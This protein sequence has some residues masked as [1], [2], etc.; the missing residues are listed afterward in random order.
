[1]WTTTNH[2]FKLLELKFVDICHGDL[3]SHSHSEG[4][5][6]ENMHRCHYCN[7]HISRDSHAT[8]ILKWVILRLKLIRKIWKVK[9]SHFTRKPHV[10]KTYIF[11]ATKG[12]LLRGGLSLAM[13]L[14]F[15]QK[16]GVFGPKHFCKPCLV[17]L[18]MRQHLLDPCWGVS[19]WVMFLRFGQQWP[20]ITS[21][22]LNSAIGSQY[23]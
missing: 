13:K 22:C 3:S 21:E 20:D 18:W 1:M 16:T 12:R 2:S 14:F 11:L 10:T 5:T 15:T 7:S 8:Y 19:E 17:H 4:C 6:L 23:W 9:V